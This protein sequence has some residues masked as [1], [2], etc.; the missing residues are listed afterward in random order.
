MDDKFNLSWDTYSNHLKEMIH[1]MYE[2]NEYTDV[3]LVSEDRKQFKAHRLVLSS[4]SPLFKSIISESKNPSP[5]IYLRG[6]QSCEIESILHFLYLGQATIYNERMNEFLNVAKSLELLMRPQ[7]RNRL[8]NSW[9]SCKWFVIINTI[10]WVI[11]S[12]DTET[13]CCLPLTD[14][15]R[16][17]IGIARWF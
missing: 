4:C 7:G 10:K 1:D 2:K 3:T 9:I 16:L 11:K 8:Y 6:I 12:M 14:E 13:G 17:L 5:F 15:K